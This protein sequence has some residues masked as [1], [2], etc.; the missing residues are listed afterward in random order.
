MSLSWPVSVRKTFVHLGSDHDDGDASDAEAQPQTLR[1]KTAPV[2]RFGNDEL[3]DCTE[4]GD[5]FVSSTSS[6]DEWQ[7]FD[8]KGGLG[9]PCG[10][11]AFSNMG[12]EKQ[13]AA[14]RVLTFAS[15][16][17]ESSDEPAVTGGRHRALTWHA[18]L[19]EAPVD[20]PVFVVRRTEQPELR[21]RSV[22]WPGAGECIKDVVAQ[23]GLERIMTRDPFDDDHLAHSY[24][25]FAED[26][27][28]SS[29]PDLE[30]L[31]TRD[32]FDLQE[33]APA[34]DREESYGD[35]HGPFNAMSAAPGNFPSQP[36]ACLGM[37][38]PPCFMYPCMFDLS[39]AA[40]WSV[41]AAGQQA[42]LRSNPMR[43]EALTTSLR[44]ECQ[45]SE[46]RCAAPE[47]TEM[48][49][50]NSV[51]PGPHDRTDTQRTTVMMRNLPNTYTRANVLELLDAQGFAGKYDF[52]Y[53]PIDFETRAALGYVF[54]NLSST[55]D[56]RRFIDRLDGFRQWHVSTT[57]VCS[58]AWSQSTQGLEEH[59]Q[60][61][62][63]SPLMHE[64]VPDE[65][66]PMLFEGGRRVAFPPPTKKIKAPR[67]GSKLMLV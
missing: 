61:Y 64:V 3:S 14:R 11:D 40:Q 65:Y 55:D 47:S 1:S 13:P 33:G 42:I 10:E 8:G 21:H 7:A 34:S 5:V 52:L 48:R 22:T 17:S 51:A 37:A 30:R 25:C 49:P 67:K 36:T 16:C 32:F 12:E 39:V 26:R 45:R 53:F 59:V 4:T 44:C 54:V 66:R 28:E 46:S 9:K 6:D 43:A 56:A 57:K 2:G 58:V 50:V 60:R 63:N 35:Q 62:R 15:S 29:Q 23:P 19:D 20:E 41:A 27:D 31:V 38:Q 18:S 24:T